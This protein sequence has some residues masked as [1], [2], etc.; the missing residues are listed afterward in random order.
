M[1]PQ[2]SQ[3]NFSAMK[4]ENGRNRHGNFH[5]MI[6]G[7]NSPSRQLITAKKPIEFQSLDSD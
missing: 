7:E 4:F 3:K 1:Q 2:A 5:L 6:V